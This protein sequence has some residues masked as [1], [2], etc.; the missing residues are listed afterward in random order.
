MS[1]PT[2]WTPTKA[3]L[4][5]RLQSNLAAL[6]QVDCP[7]VHRFTPGLYVREIFMP[8]GT[9]I[10]SKLHKTE[11]PYV[12]SKGHARVWTEEAGV[13]DIR[14]PHC[15]ITKPGTRRVLLIVED[16]VWTTFHPTTETDVDKIE[17][18]IIEPHRIPLIE[19][20]VIRKL[21]PEEVP[22]LG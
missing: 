1:P 7:L 17:E 19:E 14:A 3:G 21:L 13:V 11:H 10:I 18:Q 6:P 15:G 22:C 12:V 9:L 4:V 16:C 5:D 20:A 8:K 2:S